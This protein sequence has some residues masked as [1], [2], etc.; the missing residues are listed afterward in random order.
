MPVESIRLGW[1]IRSAGAVAC[2]ILAR[3]WGFLSLVGLPCALIES[4]THLT[5]LH[6][7]P[8]S[9]NTLAPTHSFY[10]SKL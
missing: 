5:P 3:F 6:T 9:K 4:P 10:F 8:V 1:I 7:F 2:R